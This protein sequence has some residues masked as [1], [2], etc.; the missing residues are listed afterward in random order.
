MDITVD[1]NGT[2]DIEQEVL[3]GIIYD[4]LMEHQDVLKDAIG[5]VLA[6]YVLDADAGKSDGLVSLIREA[7]KPAITNTLFDVLASGAESIETPMKAIVCSVLAE[8]GI[9]PKTSVVDKLMGVATE[10]DASIYLLRNAYSGNSHVDYDYYKILCYDN[11]IAWTDMVNNWNKFSEK[12]IAF[13]EA[14]PEP[15]EDATLLSEATD[16]TPTSA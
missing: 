12:A 8:Y 4:Q 9:E 7:I 3:S 15:T 1:V 5:A 10:T 14:N 16:D 6:D 11:E 2:L 13:L